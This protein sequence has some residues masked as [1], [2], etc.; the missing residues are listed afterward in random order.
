MRSAVALAL[1]SSSV[2][3]AVP[4]KVLVIV[5]DEHG[6]EIAKDIASIFEPILRSS[7]AADAL[8]RHAA[9]GGSFIWVGPPQQ[10]P[11]VLWMGTFRPTE[12]KLRITPAE[13]APINIESASLQPSRV[14]SGFLQ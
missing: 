11:P 6:L 13:G 3:C 7:L 1:W 4:P 2:F 12:T 8:E 10:L 9:S 14:W 5:P